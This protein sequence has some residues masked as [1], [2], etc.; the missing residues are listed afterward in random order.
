MKLQNQ[1]CSLVQAKRF[2]ELGIFQG[3]SLFFYDT[4]MADKNKLQ[5]N[6]GH[7]SGDSYKNSESCFS[8]FTLS[9][10]GQMLGYENVPYF[11]TE[12]DMWMLPK[13]SNLKGAGLGSINECEIRAEL[14]LYSIDQGLTSVETCNSRLVE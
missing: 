13:G 4:W 14:L 10:L 5:F 9:E 2:S 12:Y 7:Q 8:A 11:S 1:V 3:Q 6:S